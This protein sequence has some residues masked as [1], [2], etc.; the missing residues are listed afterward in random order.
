[1]LYFLYRFVADVRIVEKTLD[2]VFYVYIIA[3]VFILFIE[4]FF[5]GRYSL[6]LKTICLVDFNVQATDVAAFSQ[7]YFGNM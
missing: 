7:S 4:V 6:S 5:N 2:V 1:M 3:L